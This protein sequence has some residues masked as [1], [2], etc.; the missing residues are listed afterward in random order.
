MNP[1]VMEVISVFGMVATALIIAE[2][3]ER[4]RKK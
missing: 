1:V 4:R 2:V 3:T